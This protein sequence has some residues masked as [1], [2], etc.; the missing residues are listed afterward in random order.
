[1]FNFWTQ[2]SFGNESKPIVAT[3]NDATVGDGGDAAAAAA[4]SV[5]VS[6]AGVRGV[7]ANLQHLQL[8]CILGIDPELSDGSN[9]GLKWCY[10]K[11]KAFNAAVQTMD[12][13]ANG[14]CLRNPTILS[15]LRYFS[16]NHFGILM[17]SNLFLWL[18]VI[19]RWWNG[20]RIKGKGEQGKGKRKGE[21]EGEGEEK[22]EGK[23]KGEGAGNRVR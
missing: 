15:W 5:F 19:H 18:L 9:K 22:R 11:Y 6:E 2:N 7:T 1:M 16:Q 20:L 23:G 14:L 3:N 10:K 17:L 13:M 12:E 21:G 4:S 8:M